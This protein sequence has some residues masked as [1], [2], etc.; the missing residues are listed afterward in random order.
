V[1]ELPTGSGSLELF[2]LV[3]QMQREQMHWM[4]EQQRRQE[5]MV[6]QQ[7]AQRELWEG[8]RRHQE[9]GRIV[10]DKAAEHGRC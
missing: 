8:I 6:A 5:W 3:M 7:E 4:P 2:G 10:A 1:D 9:G